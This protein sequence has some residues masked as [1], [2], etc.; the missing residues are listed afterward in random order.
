MKRKRFSAALALI[1]WDKP[2]GTLLLLT[3]ALWSLVMASNGTPP[4]YLIGIF[5]IGAFLMRSAGCA[6]NDLADH[7]FDGHVERTKNRPLPSGR[8]THLEAFAI[9]SGL[10]LVAFGLLWWLNPL[11]R[12]LSVIAMGLAVVY[13][14]TKR[15]F[16]APQLIMG[17]AFGWGA[18]MAWAAVRN[19]L[20]WTTAFVFLA[21]VFWAAAYDTIYAMM[22]R[23]EDRRVGL[24]STAILFEN[25]TRFAV[26]LLFG[27]SVIFLVL[28]GLHAGLGATYYL[29]VGIAACWFF[30]QTIA[31][32][33]RQDRTRLFSLF[34][35]H[36]VI[37]FIILAAC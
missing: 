11:T 3:P 13:P 36:A 12:I 2:Y 30:Y 4:V 22:D 10:S 27:T 19:T 26:G 24:H 6:I 20:E 21:T 5:V 8:L 18:V 1:R 14:F 15:F 32:G 33:Y 17:V 34:K 37:G 35:S 25:N 29:A 7:P 31:I 28:A 23:S 9:F 16:R